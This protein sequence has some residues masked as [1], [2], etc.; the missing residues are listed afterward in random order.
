MDLAEYE[1]LRAP[2][3]RRHRRKADSPN[4]ERTRSRPYSADAADAYLGGHGVEPVTVIGG[5][6]VSG[7]LRL[8]ATGP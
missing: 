7:V 8:P 3:P 6:G 4:A 5:P 1:V 2:T